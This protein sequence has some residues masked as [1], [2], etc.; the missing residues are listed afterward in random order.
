MSRSLTFL[1]GAALVAACGGNPPPMALSPVP[2]FTPA[3]TLDRLTVRTGDQAVVVDSPLAALRQVER[4]VQDA[5]GYLENSG[6]STDG[7][8][9]LE[10]RVP[11]ARLDSIMNEVAGLGKERRRRVTGVDVTDQH[12]DLA[13]RLL[14]TIAL[15]D[16]LQQLLARAGTLDEVLKLEKEIARLQTEIDGLQ[17]RLAQLNSRVTLASLSVSLETKRVLGPVAVV[18]RGIWRLGAKLFVIK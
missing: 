16:R 18:G 15:R 17:G 7:G 3:S 5:G 8:V 11:A 4:L 10:G 14:S 13:A 2:A 9:R 12:A 6:G 1:A